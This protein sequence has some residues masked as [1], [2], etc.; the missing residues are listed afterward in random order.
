MLYG[1]YAR[2]EDG[3]AVHHELRG[4]RLCDLG[5]MELTSEATVWGLGVVQHID[6]AAMEVF[7]SY[8]NYSGEVMQTATRGRGHAVVMGGARIRF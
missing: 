7:L 3:V 1:E 6:A 4:G 5:G 2:V 8:R